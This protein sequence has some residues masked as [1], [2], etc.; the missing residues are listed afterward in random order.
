MHDPVT[1]NARITIPTGGGGLYLIGGEADITHG[2]NLLPG[3][4]RVY[5]N[6]ATEIIKGSDHDTTGT[7]MR[8]NIVGIYSLAA[9]DY[10]TLQG[11]SQ[12]ASGSAN[13][14]IFWATLIAPTP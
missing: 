4:L 7:A 3:G 5:L 10:I 9:G 13:N 8:F 6:G 11:Y 14:A 2:T 12:N 1:N